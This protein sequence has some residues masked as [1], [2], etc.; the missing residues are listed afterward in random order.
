MYI[1]VTY[2]VS[3]ENLSK[4]NNL[5]RQYLHWVQNSVFEGEISESNLQE[6]EKKLQEVINLEKESVLIFLFK[7]RYMFTKKV[8]GIE[9]NKV[10]NIL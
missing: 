10:S 3:I 7:S 5:L 4:V 1:I 6:L 2:D 9:K 8:I